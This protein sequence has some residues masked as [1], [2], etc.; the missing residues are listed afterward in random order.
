MVASNQ[1][2][3]P[4]LSLF[5]LSGLRSI[6]RFLLSCRRRFLS[7]A[8][9]RPAQ[10][11]TGRRILPVGC[12]SQ[13]LILSAKAFSLRHPV[14]RCSSSS[15]VTITALLFRR[16]KR[17]V[18]CLRWW[19]SALLLTYACLAALRDAAAPF[20]AGSTCAVFRPQYAPAKSV[21]VS[22]SGIAFANAFAG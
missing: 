19:D 10:F 16:P 12:G 5:L 1:P 8:R 2:F 7:G 18:T 14:W 20:Y 17:R 11:A 21:V 3:Y 4:A 13:I 22:A 6:S 15:Y 9:N